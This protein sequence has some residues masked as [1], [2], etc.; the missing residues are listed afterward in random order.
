MRRSTL[1][2]LGLALVALT[3]LGGTAHAVHWPLLGGDG[4]RSGNQPVGAGEAPVRFVY[5]KVAATD[6]G[7]KTSLLT[8][9]GDPATQRAVYGTAD[10][11]VH[12]RVLQSG[13]AVGPEAGVA[14]DSGE[15][16]ADVFGGPPGS[17]APSSVSFA[18]SST[19]GGLGQVFAVH[20]DDD[21][22]PTG[23]IA[24]AQLDERTGQLVRDEPVAG[25]DGF[26]IRSSPLL[27]AP[28][29]AGDRL[30]FFVAENGDDERVFRV[31][32]ADA[33]ATSAAIGPA[34][35]TPDV[36]AVPT[37]SPTLLSLR[38]AAGEPRDHVAV[39]T[40]APESNV[41]TFATADLAAGPVSGD[42][43]DAVMTPA[44][45][46]APDGT[47]PRPA[48]GLHVAAR[49]GESTVVHT[50]VQEG[51]AQALATAA[52]S[53]PL[54]GT[55]APA[56][57]TTHE[58]A[59][60]GDEGAR[61]V[62]TTSANL[63]SLDA[64]GLG[65]SGS[66]SGQ[67]L[68]PGTTGF[69]Q[70]TAAVS[71]GLG[72]VT[73]DSGGQHVFAVADAQPVDDE[74][75]TEDAGNAEPRAAGS[76]FGQP[77]VS[78]SF[79][80]FGGPNG[81]FV[82]ASACGNPIAGGEGDDTVIGFRGGDRIDAGDGNDT[83]R[84]LQGEDCVSGGAGNDAIS[85]NDGD[86]TVRGGP[87]D[88]SV[89]GRQGDDALSGNAGDD[90]VSANNGDDVV[91]G[92]RGD[93]GVSGNAGDDIVRGNA[94]NDTVFGRGGSDRLFGNAGDD[95]VLGGAGQD[96]LIGNRGEDRLRGGAGDD[97]LR[98]FADD[99]SLFGGAGD[100]RMSG[101][102]ADDTVRGGAG[103]DRIYGRGGRDS[104]SGNAGDDMLVGG[105]GRDRIYGRAGDDRILARDGERDLVVCGIGRDRAVADMIDVVRGCEHVRRG[106]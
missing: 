41:R 43:G 69:G 14:I 94:G 52:S 99:D 75:F 100:D 105:N 12:L 91:Y 57:A 59:P 77:A 79:V 72:Y 74:A 24:I 80:Q 8:S 85:G 92:R 5:S 56:L 62:V 10:G 6:R 87:G 60:E 33:G 23:D 89:F 97:V 36:D 26:T 11:R 78:R 25:T 38:D 88:D 58:A 3:A 15:P 63:Y 54:A 21:Q 32:I 51:N 55:P 16:D 34:T 19:A 101:N 42:L 83:V 35:S 95:R 65:L 106:S 102:A 9:A 44:V 4:G 39:G 50:L 82:Y 76:G 86:D 61:V 31:P 29:A 81:L 96:Q 66:L 103:D 37:A 98:G 27:T 104:L 64:Q 13:A 1:T 71:G 7:V 68:S 47:P 18:E 73:D 2:T 45:P 49:A 67:P 28:D 84:G 46:V 53:Q 30:L 40:A 17:E 22:S 93:D 20:N 90:R 48:P 70:T